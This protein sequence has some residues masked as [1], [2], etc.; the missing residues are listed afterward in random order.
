M[1]Y[2]HVTVTLLIALLVN[3]DEGVVKTP[4]DEIADLCKITDE[5]FLE[6]VNIIIQKGI[7]ARNDEG[8]IC[9]PNWVKY[10]KSDSLERVRNYRSRHANDEGETVTPPLQERYGNADVTGRSKKLDIKK[11]ASRESE[12]QEIPLVTPPSDALYRFAL[13]IAHERHAAKPGAY[14][15]SIATKPEIV[16]MFEEAQVEERRKAEA[17]NHPD[18]ECPVCGTLS[19]AGQERICKKCRFPMNNETMAPD[20]S[21]FVEQFC[22]DHAE[23]LT[24][25]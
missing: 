24:N 22:A 1:R 5:S 8:Q 23:E 15:K 16:A 9:F 11:L 20:G 7:I 2:G 6:L 10:Q 14:A 17:A 3:A 4:E 13:K 25:A 12:K 21:A 18:W 19:P